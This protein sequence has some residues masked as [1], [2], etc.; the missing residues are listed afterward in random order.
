MKRGTDPASASRA[1]VALWLAIVL[2]LTAAS[3]LPSLNADFTNWDDDVYVTSNPAVQ[4]P[5]VSTLLGFF[6]SYQNGNYHPL[7]MLT[8][9]LDYRVM[10]ADARIFHAVNLMLHLAS[11]ALVLWLM[12]TLFSSLEVA[13]AA[14]VLFGVHPM[15]V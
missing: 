5:S 9:A 12:L 14:A 6:T 7:T 15:H 8:L 3:Y 2:A 4:H 1:R 13:V 11:T 10:G